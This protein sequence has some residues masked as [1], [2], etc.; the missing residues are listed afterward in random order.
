MVLVVSESAFGVTRRV[1]ELEMTCSWLSRIYGSE[2]KFT[3]ATDSVE[4]GPRN[5][6]RGPLGQF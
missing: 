1:V 2:I 3:I 4:S 5:D 6:S